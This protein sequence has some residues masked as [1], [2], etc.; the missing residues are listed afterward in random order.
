VDVVYVCSTVSEEFCNGVV[1]AVLAL[2]EVP[3]AYGMSPTEVVDHPDGT[4]RVTVKTSFD[5][6][7]RSQEILSRSV[8]GL[9]A[10]AARYTV[11]ELAQNI[12]VSSVAG[13]FLK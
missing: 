6:P 11:D 8:D 13:R 1:Y 7:P 3:R 4:Q 12:G 2:D 5:I 10:L 9:A